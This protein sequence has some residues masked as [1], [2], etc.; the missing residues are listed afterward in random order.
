MRLLIVLAGSRPAA[1]T[2]LAILRTAPSLGASFA[3]DSDDGG[4][5]GGDDGGGISLPFIGI[6]K[7]DWR[8]FRPAWRL[9]WVLP[10]EFACNTWAP[11]FF[12]CLGTSLALC[13]SSLGF[14]VRLLLRPTSAPLPSPV[15][16]AALRR[17]LA[18]PCGWTWDSR[19]CLCS[20]DACFARCGWAK[21]CCL[22]RPHFHLNPHG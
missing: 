15:R 22:P 1:P 14:P 5:I 19:H 2:V 3:L 20:C 21:S 10:H 11:P 17:S 13:G 16:L 8:A 12:L 9:V 18:A 6:C 7:P 4:Y